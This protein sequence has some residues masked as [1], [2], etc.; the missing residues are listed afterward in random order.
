ML[1]SNPSPR[2]STVTV[3]ARWARSMA[4]CPAEFAAPITATSSP[5]TAAASAGAAP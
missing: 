3:R 1:R 2:H 4:A 5:A